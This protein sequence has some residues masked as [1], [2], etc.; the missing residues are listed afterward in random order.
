[1]AL[2][3]ATNGKI[4]VD[5]NKELALIEHD[6]VV[7]M[8]G[9]EEDHTPSRILKE[10]EREFGDSTLGAAIIKHGDTE[11]V[12]I[13]REFD[14]T[15]NPRSPVFM[16]RGSALK[17]VGGFLSGLTVYELLVEDLIN[18]CK[19][20]SVPFGIVYHPGVQFKKSTYQAETCDEYLSYFNTWLKETK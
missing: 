9:G 5:K 14:P 18:R 2:I 17:R 3:T 15:G 1:M 4:A 6:I 19:L 12:V 13:D 16:I 7:L 10:V 20:S 11:S 8:K